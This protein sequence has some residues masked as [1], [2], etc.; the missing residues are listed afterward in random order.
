MG[1]RVTG[2]DELYDGLNKLEKNAKKMDGTH[3]VAFKDLFSSKFM[4][5]YTNTDDIYTFIENSGL[6]IK[7]QE[8]FNKVQN[9][10]KWDEYVSKSS[11]FGSWNKMQE[12]A[13]QN[14][15]SENLFKGL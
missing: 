1:S 5:R 10:E 7:D 3:D 14:Y 4:K 13:L 12:S 2:F 15:I 8:T 6:N 11:D 9:T